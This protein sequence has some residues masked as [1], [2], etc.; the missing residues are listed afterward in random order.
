MKLRESGMPDEHAW[1]GFFD[2]EEVLMR[3]DFGSG[4]IDAVDYGCGYGTFSIPAAKRIRGLL[5][6][7]DIDPD[8][9]D[10][11]R[12]QARSEGLANLRIV[13]R[14]LFHDG[15]GLP[16]RSIDYVLLF[17]I[18]HAEEP[19]CLL[20]ECR[21]ILRDGTRVGVLHWRSDI[22]TPRG[23]DL[24]IRPRPGQIRDWAREAGLTP[25]N[26]VK[27]IGAYHFGMIL[28]KRND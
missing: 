20:R 13:E 17:N 12:K 22:P 16:D 15:T 18:L 25:G 8:M 3:L 19:L 5:H 4:I 14:D 6:A 26:T 2:A 11:C 1:E 7:F 27:T 9:L 10:R 23:P 21:R 28:E 24:S